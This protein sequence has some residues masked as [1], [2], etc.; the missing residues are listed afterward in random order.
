[1]KTKLR[2]KIFERDSFT[3]Q[4]CGSK[5]PNVILEVDHIISR[6]DGGE[7]DEMN[8]I[9]SC[10]ACNRGK[11]K[12]SA[13][14]EKIRKKSFKKELAIIQEEKSQLLAYYDFKRQRAKIE[15]EKMEIFDDEWNRLSGG[16]S[17]LSEHGLKSIKLLI[18]RHSYTPDMIIDAM[19]IAWEKDYI[20]VDDKFRYMCGVLKNMTRNI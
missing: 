15:A 20:E 13:S 8:L 2:Y 12:K 9:T 18:E 1:M 3:C 16:H 7:D 19:E 6:F 5:P 4:Y 11:S 10:F 14:V 17:G